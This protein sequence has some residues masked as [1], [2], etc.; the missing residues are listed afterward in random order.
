MNVVL[1]LNDLH[2]Q[3]ICF[4]ETKKNIV[5]DGYFTKIL[6]SNDIVTMNGIY[7]FF[8][9]QTIHVD[10]IINKNIMSFNPTELSNYDLITKI[11]SLEEK[12]IEY[13]KFI[14][15][16]TKRG[17]YTMNTQLMTG[18]L[19]LYKETYETYFTNRPT[20]STSHLKI[21]LK[22]SGVWENNN[23]IGLTYKFIE[24]YGG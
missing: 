4:L 2:E 19:K 21:V 17:V 20:S 16:N 14:N 6:Y 23:E 24:M 7:L 18:R 9:L 10:K 5:I 15:S 22:I 8:P 13:Y 12:I 3:Y 11:S 1:D